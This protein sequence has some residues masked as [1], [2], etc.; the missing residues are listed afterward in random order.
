M[1]T[2][3]T[4]NTTTSTLEIKSGVLLAKEALRAYSEARQK[5]VGAVEAFSGDHRVAGI[6]FALFSEPAMLAKIVADIPYI[7]IYYETQ[8]GEYARVNQYDLSEEEMTI[9]LKRLADI[10]E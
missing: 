7:W 9:L 3:S 8:G 6:R 2:E 5:A 4:N 10:C 1:T